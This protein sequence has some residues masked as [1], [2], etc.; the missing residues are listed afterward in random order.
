MRP[1]SIVTV[2]LSLLMVYERRKKT[3]SIKTRII[4]FYLEEKIFLKG[5]FILFITFWI[6]PFNFNDIHLLCFF[7]QSIR[8]N[9]IHTQ[10]KNTVPPSI[11]HFNFG[12]KP[13]NFGD[14]ASVQCLVTSG[15]LP[16]DFKWYFNGRPVKEYSGITTVKLG[17]RNSVLNIDSVTGKH[18][19]NYTCVAKTCSGCF[20]LY[21]RIDC[22]GYWKK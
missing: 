16:I 20:E 22:Q 17:N 5:F 18:S 21:L 4:N 3:W 15:D 14:S 2:L 8:F 19:G 11:A 7:L 6:F 13:S 12:D 9:H 10:K 1:E